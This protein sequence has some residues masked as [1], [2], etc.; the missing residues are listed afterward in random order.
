MHTPY[1]NKIGAYHLA[2]DVPRIV[3]KSCQEDV[4]TVQGLREYTSHF[5]LEPSKMGD[6]SIWKPLWGSR[7]KTSIFLLG[8][9]YHETFSIS[10]RFFLNVLI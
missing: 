9:E 2:M 7:Y 5:E 1:Q 6:W 4:L 3:S 10:L 8:L